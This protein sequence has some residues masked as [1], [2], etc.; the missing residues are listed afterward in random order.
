MRQQST[1]RWTIV[2]LALLALI[3]IPF[4]LWE[5]RITAY[6]ESWLQQSHSKAIVAFVVA[7]L[8]AADI[9]LPVPSSLV[10][11]AGGALLGWKV[12]ATVSLLGMTGG[13]FLGYWVGATSGATYVGRFVGQE[14]MH[15]ARKIA[16][17]IGFGAVVVARAVPVLAEATAVA[18]GLAGYPMRRFLVAASLSNLG[19]SL[20]Y[21]LV[22]AY[23]LESGAFLIAF[24][25]A[26]LVPAIGFGVWRWIVWEP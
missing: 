23:A 8:L 19:V 25:A 6:A 20:A 9:L 26:I 21:S 24:S 15:R 12:G 4:F 18:A 5:A 17:N 7:G 10:S 11:V 22:G 16:A 1:V 13:C 14:E 3:L 2:S